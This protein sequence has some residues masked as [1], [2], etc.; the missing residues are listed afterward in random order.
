MDGREGEGW[1]DGSWEAVGE[2]EGCSGIKSPIKLH[3]GNCNSQ[4]NVALCD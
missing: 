3:V 2:E 4:V 1:M